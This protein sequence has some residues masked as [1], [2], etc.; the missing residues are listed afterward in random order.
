[1]MIWQLFRGP[2]FITEATQRPSW[3]PPLSALFSEHRDS[4][5]FLCHHLQAYSAQF[6]ERPWKC[7]NGG[8]FLVAPTPQWVSVLVCLPDTGISSDQKPQ[9]RKR[10]IWLV[11]T[12]H[13]GS[14][15][16][17]RVAVYPRSSLS[18][19]T[20]PELTISAYLLSPSEEPRL[21]GFGVTWKTLLWVC[22][23][24]YRSLTEEE[25]HSECG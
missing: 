12:V 20:S 10:F 18:G 16:R 9:E 7:G 22:W 1:M 25:D 2:C 8:V 11:A 5:P 17:T 24:P 14:Q 4:S 6:T 19:P 15:G 13:P 3:P 23:C 21:S